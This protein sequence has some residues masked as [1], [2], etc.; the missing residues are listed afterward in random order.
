MLYLLKIANNF[1]VYKSILVIKQEHIVPSTTELNHNTRHSVFF[2]LSIY[3]VDIACLT[4]L[5]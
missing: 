1:S 2:L 3:F 5:H 4:L